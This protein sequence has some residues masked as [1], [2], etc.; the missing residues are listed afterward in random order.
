MPPPGT[1]TSSHGRPLSTRRRTL[2]CTSAPGL[3]VHPAAGSAS[4]STSPRR[5]GSFRRSTGSSD[6]PPLMFCRRRP[7]WPEVD[8]QATSGWVELYERLLKMFNACSHAIVL[9]KS[10]LPSEWI[11][12][13]L[14]VEGNFLRG[15]Q[16]DCVVVNVIN[17]HHWGAVFVF[18]FAGNAVEIEVWFYFY[19]LFR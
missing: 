3:T 1:V 14:F 5:V 4:G 7:S 12:D 2:E 6:R 9:P 19:F 17:V 15:E 13:F 18:L 8:I 10:E 16:K 11:E